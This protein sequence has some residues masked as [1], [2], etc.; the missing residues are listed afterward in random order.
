MSHLQQ[1]VVELEKPLAAVNL[2]VSWLL[3]R[4]KT[5]IKARIDADSKRD[6]SVQRLEEEVSSAQEQWIAKA[7]LFG[8]YYCISRY[9]D[10]VTLS[11]QQALFVC[12][13]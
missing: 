5:A 2:N 1:T 9:D 11:D 12:M 4:I 8:T 7:G 6:T 13:I 3:E 10:V